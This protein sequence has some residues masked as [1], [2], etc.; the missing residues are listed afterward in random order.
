MG[1]MCG[2]SGV[3]LAVI[4]KETNGRKYEY[5]PG[6]G[7]DEARGA[8]VPHLELALPDDIKTSPDESKYSWAGNKFILKGYEYTRTVK[9]RFTNKIINK[10]KFHPRFDLVEWRPISPYRVEFEKESKE[11]IVFKSD[12]NSGFV[13]GVYKCGESY[14]NRHK[15]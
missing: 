9:N 1:Y 8:F 6:W 15:T 3:Q 4:T 2:A 11:P 5:K 12:S 13:P 7:V 10:S 14:R